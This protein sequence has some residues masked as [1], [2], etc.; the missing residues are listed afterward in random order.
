MDRQSFHTSLLGGFRKKDVVA[1][2]AE[3]RQRQRQE[4][5]ELQDKLTAMERAAAETETQDQTS[6]QQAEELQAQLEALQEENRQQAEE[7]ETLRA[8]ADRSRTVRDMELETL[9]ARIRTLEAGQNT[10]RELQQSRQ[11]LEEQRQRADRLEEEL[12]Q[13]Q[14]AKVVGADREEQLRVL[15]RRLERSLE[16]LDRA[17]DGPHHMVCYP[18]TEE[19]K[20]LLR[21]SGVI[22]G[23]VP[24]ETPAQPAE[25]QPAEPDKKPPEE[26]GDAT[27]SRLMEKVRGWRK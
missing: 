23:S 24:Q 9:R 5:E 2:L 1:Y 25:P 15:C 26:P 8:A 11:A 18:V 14:N 3:E 21:Q 19:D 4:L 22:L 12:R 10:P 27:V 6:R 7:L 17:M 13:L 16:L 20:T